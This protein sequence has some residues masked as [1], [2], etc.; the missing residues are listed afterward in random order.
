MVAD[1]EDQRQLRRG[2]QKKIVGAAERTLRAH[3]AD[4]I[5]EVVVSKVIGFLK[6][7]KQ[8]SYSPP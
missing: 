6:S 3:I 1:I 4:T 5:F 7:R 2:G 8:I